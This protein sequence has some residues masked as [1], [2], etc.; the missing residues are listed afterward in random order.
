MN[1]MAIVAMPCN[2]VSAVL[3]MHFQQD[4]AVAILR[5]QLSLWCSVSSPLDPWNPD[6]MAVQQTHIGSASR[7]IWSVGPNGQWDGG[8]GDDVLLAPAFIAP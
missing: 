3:L 7:S 8:K 4:V 1:G 2:A 5:A 6:G